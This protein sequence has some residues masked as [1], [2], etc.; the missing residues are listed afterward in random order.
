MT[1]NASITCLRGKNAYIF[2]EVKIGSFFR[3]FILACIYFLA[4][5]LTDCD[6]A[7]KPNYG[8]VRLTKAGETFH[9]STAI[10]SCK[11]GYKMVGGTSTIT[12]QE[13]GKWSSSI[14]CRRGNN[15][16]YGN[17]YTFRRICS[18]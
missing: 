13:N 6:N 5:F 17:A 11:K 9:K 2:F 15:I 7:P 4:S 18:M 16:F 10:Q 1:T 12:C 8:T 14:T 3:T